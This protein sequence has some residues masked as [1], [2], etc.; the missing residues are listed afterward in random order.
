MI[1][2]FLSS[3]FGFIL[4][5]IPIAFALLL[6]ALVLAW[7]MGSWSPPLVVQTIFR[8]IDSFPLMAIPFFLLAGEI[9]NTGGIAQRIIMVAKAMFG[10]VRGGLGYVTVVAGMLIAGVSG[11]AVADASAIGSMLFPVMKKE[12][13]DPEKAGALFAGAATIGPIIPPSIPMVIFGVI[14]NVSVIRLF[15]GGIIPGVILGGG[16]M[17]GWYL[18]TRGK[19]RYHVEGRFSLIGVFKACWDALLAL[20][21][22]V[23]ILGGILLGIC[24]ATEAAVVSA[25]YAFIVSFFIYREL[26]LKDM[27]RVLVNTVRGTAVVLL[28]CGAAMAAAY[29]ITTAQI[30]EMLAGLL[31]QLSG[32][33]W[34][35]FMLWVNIL[36]LITGCVMD[37]TPALLI[38]GPMLLPIA[39]KY[40]LDPVYFGVVMV[41]NLCIGL[42][43]P[44]VGNVLFVACGISKI[45]MG[46]MS[47]A[48][49]PN[50]VIGIIVIFI[51]T[52]LP[53]TIMYLPGLIPK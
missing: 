37:L 52:Y 42:I 50:I 14:A 51:I 9:M 11:S 33:S 26:K 28:V 12:G 48:I 19:T 25:V 20:F 31:L 3:L 27:M 2:L 15:I 4:L 32:G 1:P 49:W 5:G 34:V 6:T 7:F 22:P 36:L 53:W 21:L 47:R 43:T 17:I 44:P 39:V 16:L 13:Y 23:I 10:H 35:L 8:G 24:T 38:L 18:H 30:P 46:S 29:F 40:G 45:A 41:V